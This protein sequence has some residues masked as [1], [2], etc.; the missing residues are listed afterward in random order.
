MQLDAANNVQ[1]SVVCFNFIY[2]SLSQ[3]LGFPRNATFSSIVHQNTSHQKLQTSTKISCIKHMI[4][5][6]H[7]IGVELIY[8]AN[9][10]TYAK[11]NII[12][13]AYKGIDDRLLT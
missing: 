11:L 2:S 12:C 8:G 1:C 9:S 3:I 7:I 4:C 5:D 13:I 10:I 6:Y